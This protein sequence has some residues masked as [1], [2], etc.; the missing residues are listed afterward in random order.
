MKSF[1]FFLAV[2]IPAL[3]FAKPPQAP[4]L[5][6]F[7]SVGGECTCNPAT[8]QC[9]GC[10]LHTKRATR[11][12]RCVLFFTASWC[13]PCQQWKATEQPKLEA[14]GIRFG[15]SQYDNVRVF[16]ADKH[17]EMLKEWGVKRLPTFIFLDDVTT[18]TS[19]VKTRIGGPVPAERIHYFLN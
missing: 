8:C 7:C 4:P 16:D 18:Q 11:P 13:A 1:T 12:T 19:V 5:R 3:A 6:C 10:P 17:P 2:L 15:T 9:E 14:A